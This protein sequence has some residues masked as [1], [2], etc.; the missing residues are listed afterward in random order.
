VSGAGGLIAAVAPGSLGEA[1]GLRPGDRL[2]SING[3]RLRDV[4][5]VQFYGAE[6][7]LE[8]GV[9]REDG[10]Q[11][12]HALRAYGESLG[13]DFAEPL[14]DG[15]RTCRNHCPFCF[16]TGLPRGLRR[17]LYVRDDDYRLSFLYGGF[18][19]LS[20]LS[21]ADW[22][23]LAEQHLSPLYVSVQATEPALR[24]RLL[25]GKPLPDILEQIE[26]LGELGITVHAQVVI[27]PGLNDQAAL[28]RTLSDL[29]GRNDTVESVALVPVGLTRYHPGGLRLVTPAEAGALLALA[30]RWRRLGYREIG[31]RFVY[32]S[33]ELYLLAGRPVPGA[34]TYDGFPQ[35]AN[36]VGL[37]RQFLDDWG[38]TRR[39]LER[40]APPAGVASATLVTATVMAPFLQDVAAG[41]SALL[42]L[43]CRAVGIVN[44]FLGEDVTVAGLLTAE[45]VAAQLA[46]QELG[47]LVI[48]PRSMFDAAGERTLD[49]WTQEKLTAALQR[50]I[51]LAS[52]PSEVVALLTRTT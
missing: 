26:R 24:Q 39:R 19:T 1:A 7:V 11:S 15:V 33:D 50:P 14:F 52:A 47:Q 31:L 20:N 42:G 23:R 6:E 5:D 2:L 22:E 51:A 45:D 9:L 32:P 12:L 4:L 29:W 34:A 3:H 18:V 36:G 37:L 48:L 30:D 8:L 28:E 44:R 35:L 25:G 17:S 10:E 13:L 16:L 49:D 27:C 38:R 41:L 46:G 40:C 21:P 43:P